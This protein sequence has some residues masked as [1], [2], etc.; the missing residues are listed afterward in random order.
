[1]KLVEDS[2]IT[3]TKLHFSR[4]CLLMSGY[5]NIF[6]ILTLNLRMKIFEQR[7]LSDVTRAWFIDYNLWC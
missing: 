3:P 7:V 5:M 2:F 4:F 1:M 6:Q